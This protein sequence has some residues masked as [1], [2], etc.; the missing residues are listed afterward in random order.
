MALQNLAFCPFSYSHA[1]VML[2]AFSVSI[3]GVHIDKSVFL[4]TTISIVY[5]RLEKFPYYYAVGMGRTRAF[6]RR[7]KNT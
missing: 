5:H 3:Y 2:E 4:I 7:K 6:E 1:L